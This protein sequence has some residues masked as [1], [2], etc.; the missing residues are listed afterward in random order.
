[1]SLVEVILK[2]FNKNH[3]KF[4]ESIPTKLNKYNDHDIDQPYNSIDQ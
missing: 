3:E 4:I 1:M 2:K